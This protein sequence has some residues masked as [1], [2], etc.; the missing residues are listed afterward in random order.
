MNDKPKKQ[1][2]SKRIFKHPL[3]LRFACRIVWAYIWFVFLSS[4][5]RY[6]IHPDAQ[7]YLHGD[8]NAIT[9]FWHGRLCMIARIRPKG[10]GMHVLISHHNDGM[11]IAKVMEHFGI[12]T[13]HGSSSKGAMTAMRSLMVKLKKGENITITP[14]GPRGPYHIAAA[15]VS[16]IAIRAGFPVIPL[17]FSSTKHKQLRSWDRFII[18][19]PF[20]TIYYVLG[21]PLTPPE[22]TDENHTEEFRLL[23]QNKLNEITNRADMLAGIAISE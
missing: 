16:H 4:R 8:T 21:A 19:K 20:A 7:T 15:G 13:I 1:K 14:D 6:D 18:P 2:L 23:I 5:I 10:R 17:A 9:T 3:F 12:E 22:N 11:L